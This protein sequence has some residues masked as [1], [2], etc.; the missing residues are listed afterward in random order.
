VTLPESLLDL[1][2]VRGTATRAELA[3][4]T[5]WG[6][7]VLTQRLA[8]LMDIGLV[9]DAG[10]GRST[11]GRAPREVRFRREAAAVAGANLGATSIDIA[12]T[13]LAGEPLATYQEAWD[14]ARGPE[15]TLDRLEALVEQTVAD[16]PV[17]QVEV[18]GLGVGLP[19]P[20]EFAS[21]RAISPPIMPGWSNYPVR[22]RLAGH[23]G[24]HVV[25]DNDVN[26]MAIGEQRAGLARGVDDFVFVK[27]G[28]GIGAG[29]FSNGLL[30]RGADGAA[31][32]IGHIA[33][34]G[35]STV[36][37]RCGRHGCLEAYAGGA[38][39]ARQAQEAAMSGQS[40]YLAELL[41][42][43]D[44][45]LTAERITS[46]A[47]AGDPECLRLLNQTAWRLGRAISGCVNF[48]NPSLIVF[49]GGVARAGD[50]L[51]P[52]IRQAVLELSLPLA[53]R[54]LRID[55]TRLGDTAGT[56]GAAF[57]VIDQLLRADRFTW[58]TERNRAAAAQRHGGQGPAITRP[59]GDLPGKRRLAVS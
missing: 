24:V 27:V 50:L 26:T 44:G 21:G 28:T 48:F 35:G 11:G 43:P 5:G 10:T 34:E 54:D 58:W 7:T 53:T 18:V 31:G 41:K 32:D 39:L 6:R 47:S 52:G 45:R 38:A 3:D 1:I 23:F 15:V 37:C 33:V 13:D 19:G 40:K 56:I 16:S 4:E 12:V 42:M 51:L 2:R 22:D 59:S 49:G 8:E 46:G 20:V 14:I 55:I 36:L 57:A 17:S 29:I 9:S 30:H 25:I